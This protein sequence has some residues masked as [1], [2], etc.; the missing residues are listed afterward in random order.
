MISDQQQIRI[1]RIVETIFPEQGCQQ[2]RQEA[3]EMQAARLNRWL[4]QLEAMPEGNRDAQILEWEQRYNVVD[5]GS[6]EFDPRKL[7][8]N[9]VVK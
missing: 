9:T 2:K 6:S 1:T 3:R 5:F 8:A 7:T 4:E